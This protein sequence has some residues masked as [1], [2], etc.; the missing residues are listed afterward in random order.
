MNSVLVVM[1][2]RL[3]PCIAVLGGENEDIF[4]ILSGSAADYRGSCVDKWADL[5]RG[6]IL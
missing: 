3:K 2:Q 4:R 5:M 1:E 6:L